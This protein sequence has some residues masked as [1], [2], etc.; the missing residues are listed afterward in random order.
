M[1]WKNWT[2]QAE[3]RRFVTA[4]RAATATITECCRRF[5]ISRK[6][7]YKWLRRY[8]HGGEAALLAQRRRPKRPAG[9]PRWWRR[10]LL[11]WRA[12]RPTW[13]A[14]KLRDKLRRQWPRQ[15]LPAV[16]TLQRWLAQARLT[17]RRPARAR[18]G[19]RRESS[20]R[21]SPRRPNEVWTVDFKGAGVRGLGLEPLT[22]FD[23]ASRFGLAARLLRAKDYACTRRALLALFA[24]YGLP[25]AIQ[26][27]NGPPFGGGGSLGL[28]R[29]S[30]E[31]LRL[32]IQVQFSRPACP[33]DQ[34]A[35]E[36]WHRTLQEDLAVQAGRTD[37]ARLDRCLWLYNTDRAHE[38]LGM[39]RP[40]EAYRRSRRRF[41]GIPPPRRYPRSW[42]KVRINGSERAWW[43]QRQRLFGV[44]FA[45][46]WLG[47]RPT[48]PGQWEVYLDYILVGLL[49]ANDRAGMRHLQLRRPQSGEGFALPSTPPRHP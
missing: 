9:W 8:R 41:R 14:R 19:P 18:P 46:Q 33:Q 1:P 27:D 31:W 42:A 37:Q 24:R 47:L 2:E 28:S 13:G 22:V 20:P 17:R 11:S 39:R 12:R 3:R 21:C 43:A 34:A 10:R 26:V 40:V 38:A 6:T 36:R 25:R 30:A 7:G 45:H 44:A 32:G 5:Q 29:L 35:H 23:L 4:V 16:R 48:Q 15:R 49:V